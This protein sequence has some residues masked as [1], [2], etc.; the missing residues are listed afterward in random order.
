METTQIISLKERWNALKIENPSFRIRNAADA[1]KV[2]EA[3][4]LSTLVGETV[5]CLTPD[6][7]AILGKVEKLGYVMALSRNNDIVHERKGVYLNSSFGKHA[8]LFVGEDIDLRIFLMYWGYAFAV[9]EGIENKRFSLQFF[10][11]NGIAMH[12]IYL[13]DQSNFEAY[14]EI[15]SEFTSENQLTELQLDF[16]K[17]EEIELADSEIDING[18]Q[19]GWKNLKDTHAFFGLTNKFKVTRTQA[20]RLAPEGNYTVQ[21]QEN[22]L[23]ETFKKVV[24]RKMPIMVFV[25]NPGIIQIHTGEIEK[26]VTH[27]EWFNVLD[28]TFNLHVKEK[29]IAQAWIVRKPTV[30]GFVTS[31]EL[32]NDKNESIVTIFGKRKPGIPELKEW[33]EVLQEIEDGLKL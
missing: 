1:L 9:E 2:S 33:Q 7:Q 6:F 30:D 16:V 21:V 29:S 5:T 10:G 27:E 32:F 8:S 12:K 26:L 17:K 20:L 11:K 25:G 18:F 14:Q 13:T 3:E 4:L 15:V 24:E 31:L 19:E 22:A 23:Q 28:P